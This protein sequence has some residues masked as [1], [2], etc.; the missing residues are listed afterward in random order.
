MH[1]VLSTFATAGCIDKVVG[2]V[3]LPGDKMINGEKRARHRGT[4]TCTNGCTLYI[5]WPSKYIKIER[6]FS[7]AVKNEG[8]TSPFYQQNTE[9]H[10]PVFKPC[11]CSFSNYYQCNGFGSRRIYGKFQN[12]FPRPARM[13]KASRIC[14]LKLFT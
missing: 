14:T 12:V 10:V 3:K 2:Y 8:Q 7:I 6:E 4:P 1:S 11:W 9:M 13:T 5:L